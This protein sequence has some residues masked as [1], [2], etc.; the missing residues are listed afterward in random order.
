MRFHFLRL[1]LIGP[2]L[3]LLLM[4]SAGT[5]GAASRPHP[6]LNML[7]F[8]GPTQHK[9]VQ[10][11]V[12]PFNMN[13][14][15]THYLYAEDGT[16]P[17]SIDVYKIGKSLTHV[18]NFPNDGCGNQGYFGTSSIAVT[19]TN[20]VHGPCLVYI[21]QS[22]Y[23]DSFPINADGSLGS[24]VS[25]VPT[26]G[27]ALPADVVISS[28]GKF[29]YVSDSSIDLESYGIGAGCALTFLKAAPTTELYIS[30]ALDGTRLIAP[31]TNTGNIDTWTLGPNGS[32]TFLASAP[33]QISR[34]DSIALQIKHTKSGT[35]TNVFTGQ[36]VISAPQA[37]GGQ[38]NKKTGAFAFLTG[39]PATDPN[40]SDGAA[41][42]FDGKDSFLIQGEQLSGTLASYSVSVGTPGVVGS[43]S[44]KSETP[45]AVK[46]NAPSDF[47]P[48]G[49]TLFVDARY[50]GDIEACHLSPGG[51]SGC[52]SV[53]V[54]TNTTGTS[55]GLAVL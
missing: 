18:G 43:I 29:A 30:F 21:S 10:V 46:T 39:S 27:N 50:N 7:A 15:G 24:E 2:V 37:Q 11:S 48:L 51:A 12:Q 49:S 20:S 45:L 40:G 54:M 52:A 25:H 32:I 33:G 53:A 6:S 35:V 23:V 38:Y 31:D 42:F 19:G 26:V 41:V 1:T 4:F 47:A 3:L 55:V 14:S 17:D 22:G 44:F 8:R 36:A 13:S 34:P 9:V 16:C 5:A 28:D